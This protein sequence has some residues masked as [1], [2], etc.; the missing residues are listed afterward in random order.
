M[1]NEEL[2]QLELVLSI[3]SIGIPP[4]PSILAELEA[5]GRKEDPDFK[6]IGNLIATDVSLAAALLKTVNSPLYGLRSKVSTIQQAMAL[7]GLK[8]VSTLMTG[9]VLRRVF[10]ANREVMERFWDVSARVALVM[11]F[12]AQKFKLDKDSLYTFGLFHDCGIAVLIQ[13]FAEYKRALSVAN[14]SLQ[15]FTEVENEA[16]GVDHTKVGYVLAKNWYLPDHVCLAILRH[17]DYDF[18]FSS[19]TDPSVS[20]LIA[21]VCLAEHLVQKAFG[22]GRTVEWE[23]AGSRVLEHL[24]LEPARVDLWVQELKSAA[25]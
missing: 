11:G 2:L 16:F 19:E 1:R 5:E 21:T 13:Q 6:R 17:H 3:R 9:L 22:Q 24:S 10:Q 20:Q 8:A 23:K 14:S 25:L 18:A 7:L 15:R 4:R 12:L